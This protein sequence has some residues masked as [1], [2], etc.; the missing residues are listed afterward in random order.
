M[1]FSKRGAPR[2]LNRPVLGA[3]RPWSTSCFEFSELRALTSRCG[4][5]SPKPP[6][7]ARP[8]HAS[9]VVTVGSRSPSPEMRGGWCIYDR[10]GRPLDERAAGVY[11]WTDQ[12]RVDLDHDE[13][14]SRRQAN[15]RKLRDELRAAISSGPIH[16]WSH[17]AR[18]F[19]V[20][21]AEATESDPL[22]G[23]WLWPLPNGVDVYAVRPGGG[24]AFSVVDYRPGRDETPS[25]EAVR[26]MAGF[27][28]GPFAEIR[29]LVGADVQK[30]RR[31]DGAAAPE[32]RRVGLRDGPTVSYD[33]PSRAVVPTANRRVRSR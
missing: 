17:S 4:R 2:V 6:S 15:W 22:V 30:R 5:R 20:F 29:R 11:A 9:Q 21:G 16:L 27:L 7:S 1:R 33:T 10:S 8:H 14:V 24:K 32:I 28:D 26:R 3:D 31:R 19:A 25:V 23:V 13:P 18:T 12:Y